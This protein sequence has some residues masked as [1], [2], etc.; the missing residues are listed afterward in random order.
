LFVHTYLF[1]TECV[2]DQ[3][4]VPNSPPPPHDRLPCQDVLIRLALY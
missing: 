2:Y 3:K 1:L 4:L